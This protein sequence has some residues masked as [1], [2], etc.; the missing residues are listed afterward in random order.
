MRITNTTGRDGLLARRRPT[1]AVFHSAVLAAFWLPIF[2][3]L[4]TDALFIDDPHVHC[5]MPHTHTH[6]HIH[7]Y[8]HAHT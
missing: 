2:I 5:T 6:T 4:Y 3:L 1:L 8:I 7:T